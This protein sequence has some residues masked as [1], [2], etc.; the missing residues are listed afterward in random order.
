MWMRVPA[1]ANAKQK[2][3]SRIIQNERV[4]SA[5]LVSKPS[6]VC[7]RSATVILTAPGGR[8][9]TSAS[10]SGIT[11]RNIGAASATYAARRPNPRITELTT[12]VITKPPALVPATASPIARP[13][14][15]P[16]Q[17][18]ITNEAGNTVAAVIPTPNR[19]YA[20]IIGPIELTRLAIR[21]AVPDI[22]APATITT[23]ASTRSSS[24]PTTITL[25]PAEAATALG[26]SETSARFQPKHLI[27]AGKKIGAVL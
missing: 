22:S 21:K 8:L 15:A 19:A 12:N 6:S 5:A 13:R 14:R 1:A 27:S 2:C 9:R 23:R 3:A 18:A 25:T 16:N 4:R 11:I 10:T 17:L 20:P 26:N 24:H 7:E